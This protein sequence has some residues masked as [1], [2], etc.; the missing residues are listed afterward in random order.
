MTSITLQTAVNEREAAAEMATPGPKLSMGCM[1]ALEACIVRSA[2]AR[3]QK[4]RDRAVSMLIL[5]QADG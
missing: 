2:S 1:N 3:K 4:A 5:S